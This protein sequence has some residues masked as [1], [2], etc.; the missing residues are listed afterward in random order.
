MEPVGGGAFY[1]CSSLTEVSIPSSVISLG[2]PAFSGCNKLT[3]VR[4]DIKSP[5]TINQFS[6]PNRKNATLYVPQGCKAAYAAANYWKEFKQ[7]VEIV[8]ADVNK[9]GDIT[10]ADV[11]ALVNILLGKDSKEPYE[12]DHVA[13][14]VNGDGTVTIADVTSLVNIILEK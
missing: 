14:D 2:L 3:T 12:Y 10:I 11:T 8:N 6:F 9:D 1:G 5:L 4:V 7:I 13:A